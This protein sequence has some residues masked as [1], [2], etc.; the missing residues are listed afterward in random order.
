LICTLVVA[1]RPLLYLMVVVVAVTLLLIGYV[2][3]APT[4]RPF[5]R[6]HAVLCLLLNRSNELELPPLSGPG[7]RQEP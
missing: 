5:R 7:P 1:G 4:D 3:T 2:I 6:V